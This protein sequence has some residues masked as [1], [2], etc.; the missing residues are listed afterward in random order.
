[1]QKPDRHVIVD[2]CKAMCMLVALV[3]G[4]IGIGY[5]I[6]TERARG[7]L[8]DERQDRLAEIGRLQQ[9][10]Q[11]ALNVI[12]GR[13]Q[14]AAD[15]LASAADTAAV[16]AETAQAAATTAGKAAKAAGVPAA[17]IEQDRKA[18]NSAIGKANARI[19]GPRR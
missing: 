13:Q 14:R 3:G 6:G 1:M 18:L 12:T 16:A 11:T 15:T 17:A 8:I 2:I 4:G 9:A 7:L 5:G 19:A 10:H